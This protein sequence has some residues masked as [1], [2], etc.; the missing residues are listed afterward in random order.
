MQGGTPS[1]TERLVYYMEGN[2]LT[3]WR[4]NTNGKWEGKAITHCSPAAMPT[5]IKSFETAYGLMA[6]RLTEKP[7]F[8]REKE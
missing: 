8:K 4:V 5:I 2:K 7:G 3:T 6:E 1:V